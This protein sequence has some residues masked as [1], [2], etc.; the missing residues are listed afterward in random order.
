MTP[1]SQV[2]LIRLGRTGL[3]SDFYGKQQTSVSDRIITDNS[4]WYRTESLTGRALFVMTSQSEHLKPEITCDTPRALFSQSPRDHNHLGDTFTG[5]AIIII[6]I[7]CKHLQSETQVITEN[8]NPLMQ[9]FIK[10]NSSWLMYMQIQ[11]ANCIV[12]TKVF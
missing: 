11:L 4:L 12:I 8:R 10:L 2:I 6:T 1:G 7:T 3:G 9:L 5:P